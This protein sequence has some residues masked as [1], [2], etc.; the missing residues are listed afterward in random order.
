MSMASFSSTAILIR[1]IDHGDFDLILTFLTRDCGKVSSIAK[2][3][4]KSKKRFAGVLE[5]FY[6]LDIV[7]EQGRGKLPILKEASVRHPFIAIRGSI[8][9]TAYASYWA[10]LVYQWLEEGQKDERM[11]RLVGKS[12]RMLDEQAH[13]PETISILFQMKF[14]SLSGINPNLDHCGRCGKTL[15]DM[16]G[17]R[18]AFDLSGGGLVCDACVRG[19]GRRFSLSKGVVK[20]LKWIGEKPADKAFRIRFSEEAQRESLEFLE[21]FVPY[22]LGVR[23]KSLAFLKN[24]R[25]EQSGAKCKRNY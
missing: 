11:F 3:A 12:L 7:C 21:T 19:E 5:L 2:Y 20:Q 22:H 13:S 16:P 17:F 10:Q 9:K 6:V 8:E 18:L 25:A 4:K 1:R 23:P 24:L 14:L 15:D